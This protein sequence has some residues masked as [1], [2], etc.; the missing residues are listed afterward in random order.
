MTSFDNII[1]IDNFDRKF[2]K[3]VVDDTSPTFNKNILKVNR[4]RMAT[5]KIH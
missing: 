1:F 5:Q 3:Q 2:D 4:K